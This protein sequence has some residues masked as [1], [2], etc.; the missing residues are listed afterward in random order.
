MTQNTNQENEIIQLLLNVS[1]QDNNLI[2]L[3]NFLNTPNV[4]FPRKQKHSCLLS[5]S[6]NHL[7]SHVELI[8]AAIECSKSA[9][10]LW[11]QLSIQDQST[12]RSAIFITTSGCPLGGF[13]RVTLKIAKI[14]YPWAPGLVPWM[15]RSCTSCLPS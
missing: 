6:A 5:I 4:F 10:T 15:T 2:K 3:I 11:K 12:S 7:K 14:N 9:K 13:S 8:S 1:S